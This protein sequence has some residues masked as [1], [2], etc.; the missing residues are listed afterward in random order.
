MYNPSLT[1]GPVLRDDFGRTFPYLRLSITDVCNFKC[2][3][4]LPNGNHGRRSKFL[5]RDEIM[6]L[7]DAFADVGTYKVRLTGGEPT[8]RKDFTDIARAVAA[9]P[10]IT[11]LAMTTNGYRLAENAQTWRDAGV[12]HIN[13]SLDSL[14]PDVFHKVTGHDRLSEILAGIDACIAAGFKA[15]KINAVMIKGVNDQALPEFLAWAKHSPV[16]LRFIE[17]MQTGDNK[18]YFDRHHYSADIFRDQL[19]KTGWTRLPRAIEAGPAEVYAHDDY[20]GTI[21]LIAPYSKDFCKGC[22]RLR[23]TAK[24]DLRLCLFG[25]F[26]IPL[27]N[28]LQSDNQKPELLALIRKQLTYKASSHFLQDGN[29]GLTPHLASIGG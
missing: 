28:F 3:Y 12:T 15:V 4:C 16:S 29:T 14:D 26:G 25:D 19:L 7:V 20:A 2:E 6:R 17:L 10:K 11:Q 1:G 13:V 5:E 23:V 18:A 24:G 9:H 27:R 8:V 22:N 21:G